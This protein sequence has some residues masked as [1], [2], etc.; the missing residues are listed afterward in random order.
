MFASLIALVRDMPLK[1]KIALHVVDLS[2]I[3][4]GLTDEQ[5]GWFPAKSTP[6]GTVETDDLLIARAAGRTAGGGL[7]VRL[8]R[9]TAGRGSLGGFVGSAASAATGRRR[10]TVPG[11][12]IR[13]CHMHFL[14]LR[15]NR[16]V[17]AIL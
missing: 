11:S 14:L 5:V 12:E 10:D 4:I 9:R 7:F 13:K 15:F 2:Y 8:V 6:P 3:G 1:S 16:Q 17:V